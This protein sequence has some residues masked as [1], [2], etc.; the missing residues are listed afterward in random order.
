LAKQY[1]LCDHFFHSAFGGSF[2]NHQWLI[3]AA[4]PVFPNAPAIMVAQLDSTG[5]MIKD[6][7]VTPDGYAVNTSNSVNLHPKNAI[8]ER[9]VPNQTGPT[10]GD[11]LSEKNVSWAWYS[12]GW[13]GAEAGTPP[14]SFTYHHQPFVYFANYAKGTPQGKSI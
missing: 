6:G 3:A 5:K 9:L 10:I 11:R 14:P 7:A 2:L 8:L 1:T 13:N 12:G 4:T